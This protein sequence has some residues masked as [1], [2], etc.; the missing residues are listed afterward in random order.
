MRFMSSSR[1]CV[2]LT[3]L[4]IGQDAFAA[5]TCPQCVAD[6]QQILAQMDAAKSTTAKLITAAETHCKGQAVGVML[7]WLN[8]AWDAKVFCV[9][10]G[11]VQAV[12]LD[13]AGTVTKMEEAKGMD[14]LVPVASSMSAGKLTLV[15]VVE[16]AESR[17]R[18]KALAVIAAV[19]E[20]SPSF[21]CYCAKPEVIVRV[22]VDATG[23]AGK[24]ADAD[25][26]PSEGHKGHPEKKRAPAG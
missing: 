26:V 15:K 18:G 21:D 17:T 6:A 9:V 24:V 11:K 16:A 12:S 5:K 13:A 4:L 10:D 23:K 14:S 2:A 19:E 25:F 1:V 20:G 22:A 3:G 8:A 7:D